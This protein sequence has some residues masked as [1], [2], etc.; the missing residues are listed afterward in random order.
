MNIEQTNRHLCNLV[1]LLVDGQAEPLN[2]IKFAVE[3]IG[4]H[5]PSIGSEMFKR[6]IVAAADELRVHAERCRSVADELDRLSG[7]F[8]G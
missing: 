7:G 6:R 4:T 5:I 3:R 2:T 8:N 1:S